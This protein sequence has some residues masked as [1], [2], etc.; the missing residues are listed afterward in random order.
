MLH[1]E[2]LA[3]ILTDLNT[4]AFWREI[5]TINNCNTPLPSS[6]EGVSGGKLWIYGETFLKLDK[7]CQ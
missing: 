7:L 6:I 2:T 3:K 5:R 1:K 4:E